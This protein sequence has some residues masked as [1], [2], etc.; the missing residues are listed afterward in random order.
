MKKRNLFAAIL[1]LFL[2]FSLLAGC[3]ANSNSSKEDYAAGSYGSEL[4]GPGNN[5]TAASTD[6][7]LIRKIN[8]SAETEDMDSL[9]TDIN[10]RISQL[11]G[12][13]E[14]RNIENGSTYANKRYRHAQ[15][16]I[17]LPAEQLDGFVAQVGQSSNIVSN[18]ETSSDITLQYV[19]TE[20]RLKVLKV[21]EERLLKFLSE[22]ETVSE[23][24]EIEKRLTQIQSEI[25]T[26]TS[27]LKTYDNLVD[28]GTITL[29][30]TEVEVYTV[31]EEDPTMWEQISQGF[32]TSLS[33]LGSIGKGLFVFIVS[34]SPFLILIGLVGLIVLLVMRF[35][36]QRAK[37]KN[38]P[39]PANK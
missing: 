1:A 36:K 13:V 35:K 38:S 9:L 2:V 16:V 30:I 37:R 21:E 33:I 14:S 6:R 23:M 24:L 19:A 8:I 28:Y 31:I 3:S 39:P 34:A 29:N 25:E 27:Q 5:G 20:S 26:T 32:M 22:A 11:G 18:T 4:S 7:K 12:Y 17:R 15:L 10:G